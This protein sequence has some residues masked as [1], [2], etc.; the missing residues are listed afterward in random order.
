VKVFT[1]A[2]L[3]CVVIPL[4]LGIYVCARFNSPAIP[5]EKVKAIPRGTTQAE[6]LRTIGKPT[7]TDQENR[8]WEYTKSLRW[9]IVYLYFDRDFLYDHFEYDY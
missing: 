2:A 8:R 5:L 3:A 6:I 4:V 1:K 7:S 9:P